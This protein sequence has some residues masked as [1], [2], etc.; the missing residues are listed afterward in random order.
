MRTPRLL[1]LVLAVTAL[2]AAPVRADAGWITIR[3]D[4]TQTVVVQEAV[5]CNGVVK[6]G[7]PVRLLPGETI[8][9]YRAT[10]AAKSIEVFTA[11]KPAA[12]LCRGDLDCKDDNQTYS[13][14]TDGK[15]TTVKAC[16]AAT[17]KK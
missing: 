2:F 6:R 8:R 12:S 4:T 13:I 15:G 9:E 14:R 11:Q 7:T 16:S 3:N 1:P 17:A 5:T 10:T